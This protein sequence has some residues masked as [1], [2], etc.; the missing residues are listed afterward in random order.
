MAH[1][2]EEMRKMK[3][4]QLR[5]IADGLQDERLQG[6][7]SMNK[8]HLLPILCQVLGVEAHAH[9]EVVGVDKGAIKGRIRALKT[10]RDEALESHDHTQLKTVRKQLKHLKHL[11]H[12]ATV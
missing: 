8:E 5:E 7:N 12:K 6:H 1:T 11:L 10:E 9:H 4:T 2:Y 3:V